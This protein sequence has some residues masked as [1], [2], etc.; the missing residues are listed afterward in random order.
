MQ[1]RLP[2]FGV[3]HG[4][5]CS[6]SCIISESQLEVWMNEG[7]FDQIYEQHTNPNVTFFFSLS[8]KI[9]G[10]REALQ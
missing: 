4:D 7:K 1:S 6:I 10:A 2:L 5:G 8:V 9:G 3:A